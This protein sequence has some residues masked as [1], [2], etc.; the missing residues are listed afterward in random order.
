M[1]VVI[2]TRW[3]RNRQNFREDASERFDVPA[4]ALLQ[5]KAK[6]EGMGLGIRYQTVDEVA[7]GRS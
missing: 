5:A 6:T 7:G 1:P 2:T 3:K 4:A